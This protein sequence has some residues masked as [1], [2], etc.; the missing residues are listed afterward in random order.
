MEYIVKLF[1]IEVKSLSNCGVDIYL[2]PHYK[3][4]QMKT[5]TPITLKETSLSDS[6]SPP[7]LPHSLLHSLPLA[8]C[9]WNVGW[10]H[11]HSCVLMPHS[12]TVTVHSS[13]TPAHKD[14]SPWFHSLCPF[15]R[16]PPAA[17]LCL[18]DVL[19]QV[20]RVSSAADLCSS[21]CQKS[22]SVSRGSLCVI[23]CTECFSWA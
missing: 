19:W 21:L 15:L 20:W 9:T 12:F 13:E 1:D 2:W 23:H 22:P 3:V 18:R 17:C 14:G 8:I 7:S 16:E 11:I 10:R 6:L 5:L 4:S